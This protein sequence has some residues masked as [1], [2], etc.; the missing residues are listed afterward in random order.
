M[1]SPLAVVAIVD[2]PDPDLLTAPIEGGVAASA[3]AR[4]PAS[5]IVNCSICTAVS[6]CRVSGVL[7]LEN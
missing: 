4:C 1:L 3:L 2:D 7:D 5:V 6:S